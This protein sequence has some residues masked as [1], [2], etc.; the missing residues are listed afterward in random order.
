MNQYR[1]F[2]FIGLALV[3]GVIFLTACG[4]IPNTIKGTG[5]LVRVEMS[6]TGITE[7][8]LATHGEL[9]IELGEEEHLIIE[10]QE[11]LQQYIEAG[12]VNG[13]LTIESKDGVNIIPTKPIRY[14]LTV[15]SIQTLAVTSVGTISAPALEVDHFRVEIASTGD[16]HIDSLIAETLEVSLV[17]VGNLEIASGQVET[18]E[19]T[20]KSAGSYIAGDMRSAEAAVDITSSGDVTLWATDR[21]EVTIRSSG[22]VKYYGSP[23]VTTNITS[24]GSVTHLG[25][26]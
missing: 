4:I 12:L 22:D 5:D 10:A 18:Q 1:R 7:V 2:F 11:N 8:A 26:K 20:I 25:D 21:L 6:F 3:S 14:L 9:V 24:S 16:I 19:I 17:S 23:V 13:K 15:K